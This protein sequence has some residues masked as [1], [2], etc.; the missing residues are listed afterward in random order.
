MEAIV[1]GVA[2]VLLE[3]LVVAVVVVAV[4]VIRMVVPAVV[5]AITMVELHYMPNKVAPPP[6]LQHLWKQKQ[7]QFPLPLRGKQQVWMVVVL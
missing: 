2:M 1:L 3:G 5:V 4:T 6:L 7:R